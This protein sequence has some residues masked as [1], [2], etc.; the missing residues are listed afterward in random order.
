MWK[1]KYCLVTHFSIELTRDMY[2]DGYHNL[3]AIDISEV[4]IQQAKERDRDIPAITCI[5]NG[6]VRNKCVDEVMD[7]FNLSYP[8]GTF[9]VIL[10]KSTL[11]TFLCSEEMFDKIPKYL[12]GVSRT[13][14]KDGVFMVIS[15]NEPS[16]VCIYVVSFGS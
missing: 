9:N 1:F 15:F 14:A 12:E 7:C 3:T 6:F 16:V 8:D 11:D 5:C 4:V 2:L 10:D 13:L